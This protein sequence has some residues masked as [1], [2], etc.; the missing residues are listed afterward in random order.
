M[1]DNILKVALKR[2]S[3]S[4]GE[5]LIENEREEGILDIDKRKD[6]RCEIS[7]YS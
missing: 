7:T 4:A 5:S 1:E 3:H 2:I 6:S